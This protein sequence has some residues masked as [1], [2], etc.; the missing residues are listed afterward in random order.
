MA[1]SWV[2]PLITAVVGIIA[3]FIIAIYR[4]KM[5]KAISG[6]DIEPNAPI[7]DITVKSKFTNGHAFGLVKKIVPR[8]N[9]TYYIELYP[10]DIRQG[11]KI[12]PE[13]QSVV[14]AKEYVIFF[15]RGEKSANREFVQVVARSKLE[16]PEK[17]HKTI[18]SDY[19]TKE[20]QLAFL[21]Q[22]MG[23]MIVAGDEAMKEGMRFYARGN[24]AKPVLAQIREE[25]ASMRK[26]Q[27]PSEK[28][29]EEKK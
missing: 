25:N 6:V 2:L 17:M 12:V 26:A 7:I 11:G 28:S 20:G 18:E 14:V 23:T 5:L 22:S 21:K 9:N 24:I 15:A 16:L 27:T 10:L 1:T 8:K 19:E 29:T 4:I 3:T 13:L